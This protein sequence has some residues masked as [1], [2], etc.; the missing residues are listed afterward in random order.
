MPLTG[1]SAALGLSM[2]RAAALAQPADAKDSPL[3]VLDTGGTAQGA[4]LAATKAIHDGALLLLGPLFGPE[5]RAVVTAAAGRVP[6]LC[7][8][9]DDRLRDGGAFLL[10]VTAS[11]SAG[12]ILGYA[13]RRGVRRIAILQGTSA[14]AIQSGAAAMRL[15]GELGIELLPVAASDLAT[16]R[17][18]AGGE[19][20][21]ALFVAEGGT[22]F[23][24]AAGLLQGTGVQ[25][26]GTLQALDSGAAMPRGSLGAWI[27][28]PD[29]T[30]FADFARSYEE[31]NGTPP[32]AI[33]ALAY[34]G[35]T[36]VKALR[37]SGHL[38]RS[39]LLQPQGFPGV[40]G[41]IRFR[42]DGSASRT[43][44]ILTAEATG[45]TVVPA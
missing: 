3:M 23:V 24:T 12:A 38:D 20:P 44:A 45:Y 30:A 35:A 40:T 1:A 29:P 32:G 36:I 33:A 43:L 28:A 6:V 19:L 25:M 27:A 34:D 9:N 18:A 21:D 31:R 13:R 11:Q 10:G 17:A 14:W 4:A 41:A 5:V 37:A 26:L 16:L 42:E 15:Q 39:G 8:S 7:F 22:P 2:Q